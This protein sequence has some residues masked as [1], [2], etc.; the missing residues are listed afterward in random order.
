MDEKI[1]AYLVQLDALDAQEAKEEPPST[2][3]TLQEK[4]TWLDSQRQRY[5]A[6]K[7]Q[8]EA[9]GETQVSLTDP[10]SRSMANGSK[11]EVGYNV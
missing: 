6:L 3:Q 5:E 9:T 1:A 11:V 4:L 7:A 10:D 8:M 2:A